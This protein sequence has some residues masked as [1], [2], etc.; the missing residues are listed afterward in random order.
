MSL[1]QEPHAACTRVPRSICSSKFGVAGRVG[2]LPS[3]S[4]KGV[5]IVLAAPDVLGILVGN[6]GPG[7][8]L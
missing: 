6:T 3:V 2:V 7:S 8:C 5:G 1:S 4:T